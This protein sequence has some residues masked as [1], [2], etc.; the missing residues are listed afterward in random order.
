MSLVV[1]QLQFRFG[2]ARLWTGYHNLS[3]FVAPFLSSITCGK[4][5]ANTA[6]AQDGKSDVVI[7]CRGSICLIVCLFLVQKTAIERAH[8]YTEAVLKYVQYLIGMEVT[9]KLNVMQGVEEFTQ[10]TSECTHL[11]E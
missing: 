2:A 8:K 4:F 10:I 1:V 11:V 7:F 5:L 9:G 3:V 6:T